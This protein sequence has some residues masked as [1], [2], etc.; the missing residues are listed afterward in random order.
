MTDNVVLIDF[1]QWRNDDDCLLYDW[2]ELESLSGDIECRCLTDES[3]IRRECSGYPT[4]T[5][6]MAQ[7]LQGNTGMDAEQLIDYMNKHMK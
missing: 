4:D 1:G 7:L 3:Q 5:M 2:D 6:D